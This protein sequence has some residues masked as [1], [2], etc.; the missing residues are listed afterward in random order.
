MGVWG[1]RSLFDGGGHLAAVDVRHAE[2]GDD[3]A[4]GC[5]ALAGA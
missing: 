4:N 5:A 2:V 3:D 1:E